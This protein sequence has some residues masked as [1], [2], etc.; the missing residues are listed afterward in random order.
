MNATKTLSGRALVEGE[1]DFGVQYA[2][3]EAAGSDVL[4]ATN[5]AD[6]AVAFGTLSFDTVMLNELVAKGSATPMTSD[7]GDATWTIPC[8]AYEKTDGLSIVA[9]P[10]R[11]SRFRSPSMLSMTVLARLL[12]YR[13]WR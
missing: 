2:N 13:G 1:F 10:Q 12:Y 4:T 9:L 6:G 7:N 5:A 3:G 8:I 11:L